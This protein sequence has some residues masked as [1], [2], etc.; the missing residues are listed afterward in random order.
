MSWTNRSFPNTSWAWPR[1]SRALLLEAALLPSQQL[2]QQS[3]YT[4]LLDNDLDDISF[5]DHRLLAAISER[6]GGDMRGLAELPRLKGLQRQLWTQSRIRVHAVLPMLQSLIDGGVEIMLL[7]GAARIALR[8][9]AQRQRAH[10]DVDIIVRDAQIAD[11]ARILTNQG[12]QTGR[13]DTALA[14]IARAPATR[15]INFKK[16]PWGDIDLHRTAYHGGNYHHALDA[17][18]WKRAARADYFGLPVFVPEAAERLAMTLSH[19]A[20]SPETHSDWLI[21]AADIL[22]HDHIDWNY[23]KETVN[24]RKLG[25]QI[26]IGLS[27]LHYHIGMALPDEAQELLSGRSTFSTLL[28]ARDKKEMSGGLQRIRDIC[29]AISR[30]QRDRSRSTHVPPLKLSIARKTSHA[31]P[32]SHSTTAKVCNQKFLQ[33]GEYDFKAELI[34]QAPLYK[35]RIE[36][37]LN[38]AY[39]NLARFRIYSA[40]HQGG[41]VKVTISSRIKLHMPAHELQLIARPGTLL[42]PGASHDEIAKYAVLPFYVAQCMLKCRD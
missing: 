7:K 38:S 37:E 14:A 31:L 10:Q 15:A 28:I 8:P 21:D 3:F 23:F 18:L 35:R 4:W 22:S 16:L 41:N 1:G 34:I 12:W 40:S 19:G 20:W 26:R 29:Y 30:A 6:H 32:I 24:K 33:K 42:S 2:A 25:G 27:Y 9:D 11:A 17:A 39:E 36:F 5:A 13:G